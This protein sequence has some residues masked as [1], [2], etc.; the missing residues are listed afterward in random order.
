MI[1][2]K[3]VTTLEIRRKYLE[4]MKKKGWPIRKSEKLVD[5]TF[6]HCFTI[7]GA[8]DWF[9]RKLVNDPLGKEGYA[10]C[11]RCFRHFDPPDKT[12]L[13]FFWMLLDITWNFYSRERVIIDNFDF[14]KSLGLDPNKLQITY[15]KGGNVYGKGIK[16]FAD[17]EKTCQG[18]E[19]E[20]MRKQGIYIPKDEEAI[21]AWKKCGIKDEQFV[22]VGEVGGINDDRDAILLNARE[23][24]AGVRS[25]PY[26]VIGKDKTKWY[27]IGVFL[28]EEYIKKTIALRLNVPQQA[29]EDP[30]DSD[31]FLLHLKPRPLPG[32]FGLERI[33]MAV[34]GFL[35]VYQL[36]PYNTMKEFLSDKVGETLDTKKEKTIE[37]TIA[38]IPGIVWLVHDGANLLTT[39]A[40]SQRRSI[41]RKA[42][43]TLIQNL[44]SLNL[45]RDEIYF[46]LFRITID[47][48]LQDEDY[49][50]LKGLENTCY[51]EINK[52]KKRI[53]IDKR[54]KEYIAKKQKQ[55]IDK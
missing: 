42:L 31:K 1:M 23:H 24:F 55:K 16:L 15:W 19:F 22:G 14:F 51:E 10:I 38:Y 26:Y 41:Y 35:S 9:N 39:K 30:I 32:G 11:Q 8:V 44:R 33:T 43:K 7:S 13:P 45:D 21:N 36:E 2:T 37:D 47:F 28:S 18:K 52:Q 46:K 50:S 5:S 53:E 54:Q 29:L 27:E 6:P 20:K 48:Y 40:Y 25:E 34:N 12:H 17:V 3:Q 4:F 49:T